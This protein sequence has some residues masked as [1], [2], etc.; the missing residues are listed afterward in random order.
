MPVSHPN[1]LFSQNLVNNA[2]DGM[3]CQAA[4]LTLHTLGKIFSSPHTEIFFLFF[5]ENRI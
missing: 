1:A 4:G 5:P 2:K 3:S